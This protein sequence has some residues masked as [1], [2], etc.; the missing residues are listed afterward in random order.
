MLP[1]LLLDKRPIEL[2]SKPNFGGIKIVLQKGFYND[3][4]AVGIDTVESI[5][6]GKLIVI[7][8]N[9]FTC[10]IEVKCVSL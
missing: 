10:Y 1:G 2:Y 3:L 7:L 8:M 9:C 5:K 6:I 4:P